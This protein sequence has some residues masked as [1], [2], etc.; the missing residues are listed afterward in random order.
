[1]AF[2]NFAKKPKM[3]SPLDQRMVL[4]RRL[5]FWWANRQQK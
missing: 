1:M 4:N 3:E 2:R 5:R